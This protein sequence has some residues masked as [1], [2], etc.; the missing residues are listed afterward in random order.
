MR[1][2]VLKLDMLVLQILCDSDSY[3]YEIVSTIE[4]RTNGVVL[5]K[6]GV[7]YPILYKLVEGNYIKPYDKLVDGRKRVYYSILDKGYNYLD[8][9]KLDYHELTHAIDNLIGRGKK[10]E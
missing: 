1:K 2:S 3:G 5:I 9:M 4:S 8:E 6:E 10:N 7:L